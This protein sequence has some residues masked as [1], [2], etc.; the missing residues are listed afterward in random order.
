M[1]T[2]MPI[3]ETLKKSYRKMALKH[4]PDRGGD[5][6][7]FQGITEAY[8]ILSNTKKRSLYDMHGLE[9]ATQG[10]EPTNAQDIFSSFLVITVHLDFW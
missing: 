7:I 5:T 9:A 10:Q 2:K 1:S 6:K 4:H 3:I 8:E